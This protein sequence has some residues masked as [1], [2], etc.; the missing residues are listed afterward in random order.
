MK[1]YVASSWRNEQQPE[2][3]KALRDA[4]HEVYDF[5][6]PS[7][8]DKGFAWSDIDGIP[9]TRT[10]YFAAFYREGIDV[11]FPDFTHNENGTDGKLQWVP[12]KHYI[13]LDN[14]GHSIFGRKF[15]PAIAKQHRKPLKENSRRRIAGGIKKEAPDFQQYIATYYGGIQGENR[16]QSLDKPLATQTAGG[17]RHQLITVEKMQ[18]IADHCMTDF[19]QKVD[20]TLLTQLTRQTKQLVTIEKAQFIAQYYN[21]GGNPESQVQSIDKPL[22]TILTSNK[23]QLVTLLYDFD[24]KARFLNAEE[25]AEISTFPR[26]FFNRPGF[27][28]S[29]KNAVKMI[30]NAVPPEWFNKILLDQNIDA[31]L[32]FINRKQTA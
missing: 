12:C 4:G 18:F 5:R 10:R 6:N 25:L 9:T 14:H 15:N 26:D 28:V 32:E 23:A 19:Y 2:V 8:T 21:G 16:T 13:D 22:N 11:S 3:V 27:K 31:V 20:E 7:E 24:I 30:G 1:I 29:Q 17:N